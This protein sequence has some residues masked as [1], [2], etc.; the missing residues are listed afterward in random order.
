MTTKRLK[1]T[2]EPHKMLLAS[3]E[4]PQK[5]TKTLQ[6]D[7]MG[8]SKKGWEALPLSVPRALCTA[9][10]SLTV[11]HPLCSDWQD[12]LSD[13]D[14]ENLLSTTRA[15]FQRLPKWRQNDLKKKAGIF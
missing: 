14:F 7:N 2:A 12:Y 3:H 15:D 11:S 8:L 9:E 13:L 6:R 4:Q 1:V 10:V 5:D